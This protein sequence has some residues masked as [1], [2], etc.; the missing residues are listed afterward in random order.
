[1]AG[2]Y[3]Y[4]KPS[5]YKDISVKGEYA[6]ITN[7]FSLI[8]ALSGS[9]FKNVDKYPDPLSFN[10]TD[11]E[12]RYEPN[13]LTID[14]ITLTLFY[15]VP[16]TLYVAATSRINLSSLT[17]AGGNSQVLF[18]KED[19]ILDIN[20]VP[21]KDTLFALDDDSTEYLIIPTASDWALFLTYLE[22]AI[23]EK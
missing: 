22:S 7:P 2:R 1:M 21:H 8:T 17:T 5:T 19:I 14:E 4:Y 11:I 16:Y 3:G 20:N 9:F 12:F 6:P 10:Y 23:R 15:M 13:K 18:D